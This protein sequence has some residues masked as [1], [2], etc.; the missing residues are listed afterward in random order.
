MFTGSL[1][2]VRGLLV[3]NAQDE[4]AKTGV[5]AVLCPKGAVA[6]VDVR[7]AAPGT[8]ETDL[9][10]CGA[11]VRAAHAILLCGGSAF[12]L[13]A[14]GGAMR[15]LE[16][17]GIGLDVGPCKVPIVPAAVI[18]DLTFGRSDVR[19]DADMG[20]AACDCAGAVFSQ[21]SFG[22]G[23]GATV[24]KLLPGGIP[25]KGGL[26]SA[27][28]RLASGVT[29]AALAVVNAVGDVYHPH[30]G[31]LL[32]CSTMNGTPMPIDS[33]LFASGG[34]HAEPGGN[35]TIGIIATDATLTK[36]QANRLATVAHDGLARTVRPVHTEVDGDTIFAM[37]TCE[38]PGETEMIS[39][40][41][42]AAEVFARAVVNAIE[43][44]Q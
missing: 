25:H 31:E 22:A 34:V 13:D 7:G 24:C 36:E 16:A 20:Y 27:S 33:L 43:A 26:G 21:G 44:A 8:R 28:L 10:R 32:A 23:C 41:A 17:H 11:A 6:G 12:G 29:V 1:T 35:T 5:T 18:F 42:G 14:A 40:C 3:G 39:L 30:S 4:E 19:P 37:A 9:L 2:D 38:Q 15:W